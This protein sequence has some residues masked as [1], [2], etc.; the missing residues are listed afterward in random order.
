[1]SQEQINEDHLLGK[2]VRD[3]VT[4]FEGIAT[5]K[6]IFLYGCNQYGVTPQVKDGKLEESHYFDEGR[7]EVVGSGISPEEVQ[8]EKP[9]ADYSM[10]PKIH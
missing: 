4:G 1:M 5:A 3:Q 8:V 2:M 10:F 6:L 7:L 9:G